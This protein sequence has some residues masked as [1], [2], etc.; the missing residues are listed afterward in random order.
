MNRGY[1]AEWSAYGIL[2]QRTQALGWGLVVKG[3]GEL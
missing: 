2:D 3:D 1:G